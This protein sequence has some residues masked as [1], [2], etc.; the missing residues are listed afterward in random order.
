LGW[1]SGST[2]ASQQSTLLRAAVTT[3]SESNGMVCGSHGDSTGYCIT[4][5]PPWQLWPGG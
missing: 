5:G 4:D 2:V 1:P 3:S